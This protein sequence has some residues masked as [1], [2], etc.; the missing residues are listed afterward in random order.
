MGPDLLLRKFTTHESFDGGYQLKLHVRR[1]RNQQGLSFLSS[2]VSSGIFEMKLDERRVILDVRSSEK[3]P[4][5]TVIIDSRISDL[6][7][8]PDDSE[9]FLNPVSNKQPSCTEVHLGVVSTR[10]LDNEKVAR[11]M[12]K[13]IDDFR[14]YLEGLIIFEGQSFTIEDFGINLYVFSLN[15]KDSSTG[16][17]QITWDQLLKIHLAPMDSRP[18]NLCILVETAAASQ[19]V[20]VATHDGQISRLQAIRYAIS[21]LEQKLTLQKDM[22]FS[23]FAFSDEIVI[24]RTFDSQTGEETGVSTFHSPSLLRSFG[25]WIT[26]FASGNEKSPSNPGEALKQGL[27]IASSHTEINGLQTAILFFSS[28]VY[29][30]GQNPVKIAR[31]V[32]NSEKL[33]L[34]AISMGSGSVTDLMEAVAEEGGGAFIHIDRDEKTETIVETIEKTLFSKR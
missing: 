31:T 25:E 4:S 17:A 26:E 34:F 22:L 12:S 3:V 28:G 18:F 20:D 24:F 29:S 2:D 14:E 10:G 27:A 8:I 5:G 6:F 1:G 21:T 13:R 23:G 19:I 7:G 16:S 32:G 33:V 9:V 15:P 30:A 11:A